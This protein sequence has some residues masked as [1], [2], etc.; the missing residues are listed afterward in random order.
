LYSSVFHRLS[1]FFLGSLLLIFQ[2]G[3][4]LEKEDG[5]S[6]FHIP[7]GFTIEPAVSPDLISF[8]MFATFDDQGRLFLFESTGPNDM[9]MDTMLNHPSYHI[10]LLS[11]TDMDG[12][13]DQSVIFADKIP[14]PMGGT[15]HNGSLYAAA[16]PDLLKLTDEDGDGVAEQREVLHTGWVFSNNGA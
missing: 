13:F 4:S 8:P 14:F 16:P 7:D 2:I 6:D 1:Y 5:S 15:F 9:S 11:D 10:R 3:C 12:V